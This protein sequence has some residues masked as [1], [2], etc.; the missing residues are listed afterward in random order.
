MWRTNV[1]SKRQQKSRKKGQVPPFYPEMLK[2]LTIHIIPINEVGVSTGS[3]III[4]WDLLENVFGSEMEEKN[5]WKIVFQKKNLFAGKQK[6]YVANIQLQFYQNVID[7]TIEKHI[8]IK[9]I[10]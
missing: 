9:I 5:A 4:W 1:V 10:S 8:L 2:P 6:R 7:S 3:I